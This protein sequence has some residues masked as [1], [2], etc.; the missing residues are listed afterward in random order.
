MEILSE[1]KFTPMRFTLNTPLED[2]QQSTKDYVTRKAKEVIHYALECIAPQQEEKL[3]QLVCRKYFKAESD[4]IDIKP[5]ALTEA[6]IKA[7]NDATGHQCQIQILSLFVNNFSKTELCKMVHG[8]TKYKIDCARKYASLNGPG[9]IID[10]PKVTRVRLSR[11]QIQHFIEFLYS[12]S[13]CQVV[14]YG[15][16]TLH[17]SSGLQIKIP[18]MIRTMIASRIINA[19]EVL[20][21]DNEIK[22]PSRATLYKIIKVCSA[23]QRK[24]LKGLDSY[25][26]DGMEAMD[27][28]QK[29]LHRLQENGLS[30]DKTKDLSE[31][32]LDI[33]QHLK[34]D[35]KMHLAQSSTCIDHCLTYALSD[36][37]T[38]EFT[39]DCDHL[40]NQNCINCR[41][42]PKVM[43]EIESCLSAANLAT[44]LQKELAHDFEQS[45]KNIHE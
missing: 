32:L 36:E 16:K 15:S 37:K 1:D 39:S 3:M 20:C 43:D 7:Y 9:Q 17:L 12:P 30:R 8:L 24:S 23:S 22:M 42:I 18:K 38:A 19:Y 33:N 45:R 34:F 29:I 21:T 41:S 26:T 11:C 40:H 13:I 25:T 28:L 6:L 44:D 4:G 5:D 27:L 35:L 14:G 2:V 31:K 10:P